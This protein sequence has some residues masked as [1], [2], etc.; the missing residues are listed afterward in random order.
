MLARR[1]RKRS[2]QNLTIPAL[3]TERP[4]RLHGWMRLRTALAAFAAVA[5]LF[6]GPACARGGHSSNGFYRA[7]DGAMVHGPTRDG[8]PA[9]GRVSA[10]CRDGT[11]S[12]SHHHRGTCSGHGGVAAW[13]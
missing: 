8:N 5:C 13:R 2:K 6:A 1:T 4:M 10:V 11:Q 7:S 12:Y 9:Y 3:L